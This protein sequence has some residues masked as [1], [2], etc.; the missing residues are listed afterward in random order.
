MACIDKFIRIAKALGEN[1]EGLSDREAAYKAVEAIKNL[2]RD[3]AI[4]T[5]AEINV[6]EEDIPELAE[7]SAANVSV[8]SNPRKA[9]KKD[10]EKIFL[11]AM[12][13]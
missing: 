9:E 11:S 4:P 5:L 8:D 12:A 10:F 1:V 6:R 7:R 13:E 2:N 3:L